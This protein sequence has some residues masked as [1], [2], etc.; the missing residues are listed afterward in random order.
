MRSR[1]DSEDDKEEE[2]IRRG[3]L[4]RYVGHQNTQGT[5]NVSHAAGSRGLTTEGA[6][7]WS[8][9]LEKHLCHRSN[10]RSYAA[11]PPPCHPYRWPSWVSIA[12]TSHRRAKTGMCLSG[13]S[14]RA[15]CSTC[16]LVPMGTF[17]SRSVLTMA[18]DMQTSS[19]MFRALNNDI[20]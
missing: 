14:S 3:Y 13:T 11:L 9:P 1:G 18:S 17:V 10:T 6:S 4:T 12:T 19:L 16:S 8:Y 7:A 15:V 20:L 2:D 5:K